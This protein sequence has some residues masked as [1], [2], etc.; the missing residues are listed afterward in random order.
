MIFDLAVVIT[1]S[2]GVV[3]ILLVPLVIGR[4]WAGRPKRGGGYPATVVCPPGGTA[5]QSKRMWDLV[6]RSREVAP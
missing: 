1:Y 6:R 2:L 3:A 5:V 4:A